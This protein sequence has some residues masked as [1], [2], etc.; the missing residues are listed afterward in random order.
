MGR[1]GIRGPVPVLAIALAEYLVPTAIS[2]SRAPVS[3][4]RKCALIS[5]RY[6]NDIEKNR[7][8]GDEGLV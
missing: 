2:T 7:A 8:T 6:G 5:W 4:L 3:C 1:S